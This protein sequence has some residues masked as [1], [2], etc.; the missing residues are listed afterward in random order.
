[1]LID[2]HVHLD[3]YGDLLDQALAEIESERMN[4]LSLLAAGVAVEL[5][6]HDGLH[7]SFTTVTPQSP[8]AEKSRQRIRAFLDR[9]S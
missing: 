5:D 2:A 8:E 4:V 9:C 1:M 7:H 3:K 6:V